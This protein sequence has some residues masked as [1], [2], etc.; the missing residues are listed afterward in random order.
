MVPYWGGEL[1][2]IRYLRPLLAGTNLELLDI[3]DTETEK[4]S[5]ELAAIHIWEPMCTGNSQ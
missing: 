3:I 1:S 2:G 4:E 5:D